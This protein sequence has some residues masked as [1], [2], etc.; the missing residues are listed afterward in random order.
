MTP[1]QQLARFLEAVERLPP[2]AAV[3]YRGLPE[4]AAPPSETVIT[5]GIT[6]TSLDP[7]VAAE[8]GA[9]RT[10][11]AVV[12]RTGRAL[13][14][15]SSRSQ[16][17]EVVLLPGAALAPV[18]SVDVEDVGIRVLLLEELV[19]P[20]TDAAPTDGLPASIEA[21]V[22]LVRAQVGAAGRTGSG[23]LGPAGKYAGHVA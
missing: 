4:G 13:G 18:G 17:Q 12:G 3:S 20:G 19:P 22:E 14:P 21:L 7:S 1:E 16:E 9:H 8:G 6:A 10:L 11:L 5:R 15:L 23:V 2:L